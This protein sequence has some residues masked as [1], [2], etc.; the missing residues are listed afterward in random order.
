MPRYLVETTVVGGSHLDDAEGL[1]AHRFPE[2]RSTPIPH[3]RRHHRPGDVGVPSS[4]RRP[5]R[6]MG[7]VGRALDHLDASHRGQHRPPW[8]DIDRKMIRS[9]ISPATVVLAPASGVASVALAPVGFSAPRRI[10]WLA[11]GLVLLAVTWHTGWDLPVP[12]ST[13]RGA[14]ERL[15]PEP[16]LDSSRVLDQVRHTVQPDPAR[17]GVLTV[18]GARRDAAFD[19]T[20]FEVGGLRIALDHITRYESAPIDL[21]IGRWAGRANVTERTVASGVA[22]R[23]TARNGSVEWDLVLDQPLPGTGDLTI[24][25]RL[26]GLPAGARPTSTGST[27]SIPVGADGAEVTVDELIVLDTSGH[28]LHR[29][30]C[31]RSR[32]VGSG[33]TVPAP[34]SSTV[35]TTRSP[36]TPPSPPSGSSRASPAARHKSGAAVAIGG[37]TALVA[38]SEAVLGGPA[39]ELWAMRTSVD[40]ALLDPT[41]FR[42]SAP[43]SATFNGRPDVAFDGQNFLVVWDERADRVLGRLVSPAGALVGGVITIAQG[44]GQQ[45]G[46]AVS[47]DGNNYLVAYTDNPTG[48]ADIRGVRVSPADYVLDP[49]RV[50]DRHGRGYPAAPLGGLR[51]DEHPGGLGRYTKRHRGHLRSSRR[52][53][54]HH[55][56][57]RHPDLDRSEPRV[58]ARRRLRRHQ[59]PCGVDRLPDRHRRRHLR[60]QDEQGRS[61]V[62]ADRHPNRDGIDRTVAAVG[63]PQRLHLRGRVHPATPGCGARGCPTPV[64]W[65]APP[66]WC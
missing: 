12:L 38:W 24:T 47:F 50:H 46:A 20:G 42:V 30:V 65:R 18:P 57:D 51:R 34:P 58:S 52:A 21:D 31:P 23:A 33:S 8:E 37:W 35:P 55:R 19:T 44:A 3:R 61:G 1:V 15:A 10:H 49:D 43:T 22:E 66:V 5:C 36:S 41:A 27:W 6:A 39:G 28:E 4:Q 29:G 60:G 32:P 14:T 64:W 56:H 48:S 17:A 45:F 11:A 13:D 54:G 2:I 53:R 25:P 40:G 63:R 62:R 16:D 7:R 9:D 26:D 59:L